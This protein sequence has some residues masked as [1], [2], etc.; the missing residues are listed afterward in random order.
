MR[1]R[2]SEE[3]LANEVAEP[4]VE[5][6]DIEALNEALAEEKARAE[7]NMTGWQRAQADFVNYKRRTEQEMQEI[8]KRANS[9]LVLNIL[10]ILDD[11]ERALTS[12]PDDLAGVSWVDGLSLIDRKLRGA[13]EAMGLSPIKAIGEPFDPNIH[14]AVMQGKGKEGMVIQELE[15]GYRFQ[16][17]IIRPTKVIVGSGEEE[18]NKEA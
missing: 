9:T 18:E 8:G 10:P 4:A 13:L 17:K 3:D 14:E 5:G 12:V 11:L 7:T 1:R 6:E 15:K 16:D 2:H